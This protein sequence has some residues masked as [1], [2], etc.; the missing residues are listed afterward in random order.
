MSE[1][2]NSCDAMLLNEIRYKI[3]CRLHKEY[4]SAIKTVVE[5]AYSKSVANPKVYRLD[6][7]LQEIETLPISW[8]FYNK[9]KYKFVQDFENLVVFINDKDI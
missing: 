7:I 5:N 8:N 4:V 3:L 2:L 1:K 9:Q 6:D